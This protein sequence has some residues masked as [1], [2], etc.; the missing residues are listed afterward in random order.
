MKHK[1]A[2]FISYRHEDDENEE[3]YDDEDEDDVEE[4]DKEE[5]SIF[6]RADA[7]DD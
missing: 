7:S 2:I 6:C 4:D 3:E 1:Y 5:K